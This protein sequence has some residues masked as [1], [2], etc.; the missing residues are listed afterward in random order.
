VY[1]PRE[2]FAAEYPE[3][4]GELYDLEADPWEM[5]NLFFD[6]AYGSVVRD[7]MNDFTEWLITT[8]RPVVGVALGKWPVPGP[9]V[10][11]RERVGKHS[12]ATQTEEI[13]S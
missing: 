13:V 5:H 8:M 6:P 4:F 2:M 9:S 11:T 7:I 3:G 12:G 10:S 1:Y